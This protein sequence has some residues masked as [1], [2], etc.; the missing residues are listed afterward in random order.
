VMGIVDRVEIVGDV[1]RRPL[2][3]VGEG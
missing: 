2:R 3:R 1:G